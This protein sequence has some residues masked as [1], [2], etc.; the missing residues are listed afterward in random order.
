MSRKLDKWSLR[1]NRLKMIRRLK[2][3]KREKGLR[4]D[5]RT[6]VLPEGAW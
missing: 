2:V 1:R 3:W 5:K 6:E 4:Y